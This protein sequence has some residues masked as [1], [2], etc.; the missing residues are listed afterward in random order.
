[1][2]RRSRRNGNERRVTVIRLVP[3][4]RIRSQLC[5]PR[6]NG[7]EGLATSSKEKERRGRSGGGRMW[8]ASGYLD[9]VHVMSLISCLVSYF[10]SRTY[11]YSTRFSTTSKHT[12]RIS[13]QS[14]C[15][16]ARREVAGNVERSATRRRTEASACIVCSISHFLLWIVTLLCFRNSRA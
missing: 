2:L 1:V 9:E 8:N 12:R 10:L 16:G 11:F 6:V 15:E 14:S 4:T 7:E 3:R 5:R 13:A